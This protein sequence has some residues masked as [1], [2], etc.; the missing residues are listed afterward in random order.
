MAGINHRDTAKESVR[1]VEILP[2]CWRNMKA[3]DYRSNLRKNNFKKS[4][5]GIENAHI[6]SLYLCPARAL[7][8]ERLPQNEYFAAD[9]GRCLV[10]K[11]LPAHWWSTGW[12]LSALCL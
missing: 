8:A 4:L 1:K 12:C 6:M 10:S 3:A 5:E 11:A 9:S 7:R 2:C